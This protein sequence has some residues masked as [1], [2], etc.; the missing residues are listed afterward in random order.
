MSSSPVFIE[1]IYSMEVLPC[2]RHALFEEKKEAEGKM[3]L[4]YTSVLVHRILRLKTRAITD[5]FKRQKA[6]SLVYLI[7]FLVS[8]YVGI[9]LLF[10]N[11][12]HL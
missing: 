12:N 7:K 5:R 1:V 2:D 10:H 9:C 4:I 3:L 11:Q 8:S 6:H